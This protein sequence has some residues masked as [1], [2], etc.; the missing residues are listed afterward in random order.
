MQGFHHFALRLDLVDSADDGTSNIVDRSLKHHLAI[1]QHS[2]QVQLLR[3]D[4]SRK[5]SRWDTL[6]KHDIFCIG[7]IVDAVACRV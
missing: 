3:Y 6:T 2:F 7:G 5:P 1:A 4:T